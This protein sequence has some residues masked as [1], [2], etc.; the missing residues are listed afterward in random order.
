MNTDCPTTATPVA[1]ACGPDWAATFGFWL[2]R[3]WLALR[4]IQTAIEKYAGYRTER[5][6]ILDEFGNPD[7]SGA[8]YEAK[9][10][11][12]SLANYHGVPANLARQFQDEPLMPAA[13]LRLYDA[14]LGPALLLLGVA[15]LLGV[16]T[17]VSLFLMGLIY[18]SLTWGLILLGQ[19]GGIAWLGTHVLLIV[20]A[21]V[22]AKHNRFAILNSW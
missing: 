14:C 8:L 4:A 18:L 11:F 6:P 3:L 5:R 9:V 20:A 13:L 1:A 16:G 2:L 7:V 17:R 21:L 22:L 10:K 19:D 12:Y 15:L